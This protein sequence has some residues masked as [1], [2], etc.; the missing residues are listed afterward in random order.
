[1]S[2]WKL[3]STIRYTIVPDPSAEAQTP[4]FVDV[5]EGEVRVKLRLRG[6]ELVIVVQGDRVAQCEAL[7]RSLGATEMG[8]V[9]CG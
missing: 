3:M 6:D 5:R 9:P 7:L 4:R 1:M 8:T 2:G